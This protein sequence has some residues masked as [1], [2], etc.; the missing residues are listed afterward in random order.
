MP[1]IRLIIKGSVQGV[2]FRHF[3]RVQAEMLG[4]T[5]FVRNK[6]NGSVEIE[7]Q[8]QKES[9]NQ[10]VGAIHAGPSNAEVT[11]V[12]KSDMQEKA[13]EPGFRVSF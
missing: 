10:F 2:G 1:R 11:E 7:V 3:A 13:F 9:L 12:E 6:I 8:G 4:L 5:G